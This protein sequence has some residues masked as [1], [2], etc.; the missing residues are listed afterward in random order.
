MS[1]FGKFFTN[2]NQLYVY[3][4]N[5]GEEGVTLTADAGILPELISFDNDDQYI[6][7]G[8]GKFVDLKHLM[9]VPTSGGEPEIIFDFEKAFPGEVVLRVVY[10]DTTGNMAFE[11]GKGKGSQLWKI[12]GL[13]EN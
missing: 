2:R 10:D 3:D 12:S 6:Y 1:A 8:A 4:V 7:Y 13:F 5:T 11:L 9:R